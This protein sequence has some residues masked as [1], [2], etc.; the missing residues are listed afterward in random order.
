[1]FSKYKKLIL[2]LLSFLCMQLAISSSALAGHQYIKYQ[3]NGNTIFKRYNSASGIFESC[4]LSDIP[5]SVNWYF[6]HGP[7]IGGNRFGVPIPI[8]SKWMAVGIG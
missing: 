1:M 7:F 4:S 2:S 3:K 6:V 5:F 8:L